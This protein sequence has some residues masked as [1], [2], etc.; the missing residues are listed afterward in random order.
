MNTNPIGFY[1]ETRLKGILSVPGESFEH[2]EKRVRL[3]EVNKDHFFTEEQ[4]KGMKL[5]N[6]SDDTLVVDKQLFLIESSKHLRLWE[7]AATWTVEYK[8]SFLSYVQIRN[9]NKV[10]LK[11]ILTHEAVH[12]MRTGFQEK[13][14]EEF[15]AY[16]T[17][18]SFFRRFFGPFFLSAK[19]SLWFIFLFYSVLFIFFLTDVGL[20]FGVL[21]FALGF[22]CLRLCVLQY[23]FC[24]SL[25]KIKEIFTNV[26]PLAIAVSMTDKEI[27][28]I[29]FSKKRLDFND[30]KKENHPRWQ[31]ILDT[32]T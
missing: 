4:S 9:K 18:K 26:D 6:F 2:F 30:I 27:I 11:D 16:R 7:A 14:F 12:E 23:V 29:A 10:S 24:R 3:L 13:L 25:K 22:L 8:D 20:A 5:E 31:Q 19:E 28:K 15:L 21:Y 17:S 1:R 32:F